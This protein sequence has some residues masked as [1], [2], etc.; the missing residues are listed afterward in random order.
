MLLSPASR[1][2]IVS[3]DDH[4]RHAPDEH[5]DADSGH[6]LYHRIYDVGDYGIDDIAESR[7]VNRRLNLWHQRKH[8]FE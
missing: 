6:E 3:I 1:V 5:E 2:R 4:L 8:V 7:R